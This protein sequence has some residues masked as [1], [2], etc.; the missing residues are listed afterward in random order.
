MSFLG[1]GHLTWTSAFIVGNN[2]YP[3]FLPGK[4]PSQTQEKR[5]E[6]LREC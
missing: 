4:L 5:S 6:A 1:L 2:I 3:V